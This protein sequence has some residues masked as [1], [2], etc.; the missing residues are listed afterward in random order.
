MINLVCPGATF[1]SNKHFIVN[2]W[3]R[4]WTTHQM[5]IALWFY[6]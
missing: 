3:F 5:V 4:G 1:L 6:Y 2:L